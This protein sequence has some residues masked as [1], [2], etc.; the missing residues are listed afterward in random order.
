MEMVDQARV[1]MEALSKEKPED[2]AALIAVEVEQP[3]KNCKRVVFLPLDL[4]GD[5]K[6][7]EDETEL[8]H[9]TTVGRSLIYLVQK[10]G[11]IFV[12]QNLFHFIYQHNL[13]S[14]VLQTLS[15]SLTENYRFL[16]LPYY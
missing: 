14:N 16:H 1:R 9:N 8:P 6:R 7:V 11:K 13:R 10:Y 2:N 5:L 12:G 15:V 4:V 3:D